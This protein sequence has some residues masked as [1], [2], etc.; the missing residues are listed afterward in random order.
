MTRWIALDWIL[1]FWVN[2]VIRLLL[3]IL[4]VVSFPVLSSEREYKDVFW[5]AEVSDF[6]ARLSWSPTSAIDVY[7]MQE[8]S[9]PLS[10]H[11]NAPYLLRETL[12]ASLYL[13]DSPVVSEGDKSLLQR[14]GPSSLSAHGYTEVRF[15]QGVDK[16]IHRMAAGAWAMIELKTRSGEIHEIELPSIDFNRS[17]EAF[18]V[19]RNELPPMSWAAARRINTY[20]RAGSA[21]LTPA[22]TKQLNDL[23]DYLQKDKA[24]SGLTIDAHTDIHGDRLD[25]L[26]LSRQRAEVVKDYLMDAGVRPE[27]LQAVRHHGERYPIAGAK[28]RENRRVEI[29]LSRTSS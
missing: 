6:V 21:Q 22:Q 4:L 17:F 19:L 14:V 20:F 27:L 9:E 16:L 2:T 12:E 11:L 26:T 15:N 5:Q 1:C 23:V 3:S 28:A 25:N 13:M 8:P 10:I 29:R 7:F 24:V 18:N